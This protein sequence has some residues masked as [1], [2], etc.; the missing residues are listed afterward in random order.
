MCVC[1]RTFTNLQEMESSKIQ[2]NHHLQNPSIIGSSVLG[3]RTAPR[4]AADHVSCSRGSQEKD[5]LYASPRG[6]MKLMVSLITVP[7]FILPTCNC[8]YSS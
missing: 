4:G 2:R 1:V 8:N 5:V 3:P 6:A 7:L